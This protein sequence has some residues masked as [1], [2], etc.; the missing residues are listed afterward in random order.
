MEELKKIVDIVTAR[1]KKNLPLID[2]KSEN[3]EQNKELKLFRIIQ[4]LDPATDKQAAHLM[5]KSGVGDPRYKML[6][7]RLKS[8]LLNHL[9]FID[10]KDSGAYQYEQECWNI[11]HF[12]QVLFKQKEYD[13][14][15][16][17]IHKGITLSKEA[18]F[19][20]L[21]IYF[22]E[23]LRDIFALKCRAN[24]FKKNLKLIKK[25]R[26]TRAIEV[27]AQDLYRDIQLKLTK[28]LN[29]RRKNI[30]QVK[31]SVDR[32]RKL[33]E[34]CKSYEIFEAFYHLRLEYLRFTGDFNQIIETTQK[35]ETQY[36]N[37]QINMIR[38]DIRVNHLALIHA[39]LRAKKF[40]RGLKYAS[41]F[42]SAFE[43]HGP[44][45][46]SFY[47][48]QYLLALQAADYGL[49]SEIV[50]KVTRSPDFETLDEQLKQKWGLFKAYGYLIKPDK[51]LQRSFD[52]DFFFGKLPKYDKDQKGFIVAVVTL[53]FLQH[54]Q[55]K[56][57][58]SIK[59]VAKECQKYASLHLLSYF[60]STK[61]DIP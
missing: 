59:S 42:E 28:S 44:G 1:S 11:L 5:Y 23:L 58:Q 14:A 12:A 45:F 9:F 33:W 31:K 56:N 3:P 10:F 15:E 4:Q 39:C 26:K 2:I 38:F 7:H 57:F 35:I 29:S 22:L 27:E 49:A 52:Y 40:K 16:K 34:K 46:F 13:I 53:Q 32:L 6:K 60:R 50:K 36:A 54:L 55:N 47:E 41:Q 19:T 8:K 48:N 25:L 37:S 24:D 30:P 17:I 43:R 18:E 20:Y 51:R 21:T 61:P